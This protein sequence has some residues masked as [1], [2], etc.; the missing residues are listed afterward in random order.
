[1]CRALVRERIHMGHMHKLTLLMVPVAMAEKQQGTIE[2][3]GVSPQGGNPLMGESPLDKGMVIG[4]NCSF[5]SWLPR[6]ELLTAQKL[7]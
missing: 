1:M 4:G 7:Y 6:P 3:H 2:G 5:V